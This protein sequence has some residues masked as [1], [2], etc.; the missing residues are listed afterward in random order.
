MIT[1]RCTA[2]NATTLDGVLTHAKGCIAA[3]PQIMYHTPLPAI[4]LHFDS[5]EEQEKWLENLKSGGGSTL[6]DK[7]GGR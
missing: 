7:T 1:S 5:L 3:K 4:E 2:C 6:N